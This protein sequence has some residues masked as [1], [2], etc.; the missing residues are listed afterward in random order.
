MFGY[1]KRETRSRAARAL[2]T[3]K[4]QA[5]EKVRIEQ[6]DHERNASVRARSR[7]SRLYREF[8][9]Q[10]GGRF[11]NS[12]THPTRCGRPRKGM[13]EVSTQTNSSVQI[14]AKASGEA[15][16]NVQSVASAAGAVERIDQRYFKAGRARSPGSPAAPSIRRKR[17]TARSRAWRRPLTGS[18]KWLALIN[19]IASQTNLLALNATIEAARAG[20]AGRVCGGGVRR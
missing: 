7:P 6:Q 3:F 15:S 11:S 19:D 4:Q 1:A 16:V 12:A 5:V 9:G 20:E 8:E 14:A 13:S 18:A 17:P 10:A 2:A